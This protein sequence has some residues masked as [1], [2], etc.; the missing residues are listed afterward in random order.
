M[1]STVELQR[2]FVNTMM[3]D[4]YIFVICLFLAQSKLS[5]LLLLYTTAV[6]KVVSV[7]LFSDK[8]RRLFLKSK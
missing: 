2:R 3:Y 1:Y 5:L 8:N 4:H 7:T 6:L